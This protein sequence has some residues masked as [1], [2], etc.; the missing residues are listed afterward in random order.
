MKF[1]FG[2]GYYKTD[3]DDTANVIFTLIIDPDLP[4]IVDASTIAAS[5]SLKHANA[6]L[7]SYVNLPGNIV[8]TIG[9]SGDFFNSDT[10]DKNQFNPKLGITWN[11]APNTT[12]R[13][14]AFRALK[15]TLITN[16][17]LEPTQV[18]GFNQF[19]DD[20]PATDSWRYGVGVDQKFSRNVYGGAEYSHRELD[21]PFII[22]TRTRWLRKIGMNE[23]DVRT[24][25]IHRINGWH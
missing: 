19:Y 24:F 11:P 4:P 23:W 15:R 2:T 13:A 1:I 17:T 5:T 6:Y 3:S 12:L 9:A 10:L 7:Y 21:V 14:A 8:L 16:Q 22:V 18:A 25:T 20:R